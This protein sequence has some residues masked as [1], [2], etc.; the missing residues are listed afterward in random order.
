MIHYYVWFS[1]IPSVPPAAGLER[2]RAFLTDLIRRGVVQNFRVLR[3]RDPTA[4]TA[5]QFQAAIVF[6]D[7]HAF[8]AGFAVVEHEGVRSGLHGLMVAGVKDFA[9]EVFEE[10]DGAPPGVLVDHHG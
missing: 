8:T 6:V 2:V 7:A 3:N 1:L 10:V 9:V 5:R 4:D